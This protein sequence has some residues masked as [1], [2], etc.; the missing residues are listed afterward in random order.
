MNLSYDKEITARVLV[1]NDDLIKKAIK[2]GTCKERMK[3]INY[4]F[5]QHQYGITIVYKNDTKSNCLRERLNF[6][7]TGMEISGLEGQNTSQIEVKVLPGMTV[8]V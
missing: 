7:M 1:S 2:E 8:D 6:Q 3:G 4:Y 5:L